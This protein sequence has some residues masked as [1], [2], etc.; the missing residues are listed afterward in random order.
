MAYRFP[1]AHHLCPRC[2]LLPPLLGCINQN[3]SASS[4]ECVV[5]HTHTWVASQGALSNGA[6][7]K[8]VSCVIGSGG[9]GDHL[10]SVS[11]PPAGGNGGHL[12]PVESSR[13][14]HSFAPPC[15]HSFACSHFPLLASSPA[16]SFPCSPFPPPALLLTHPAAHPFTHPLLFLP[17]PLRT[18]TPPRSRSQ[19][20]RR[21]V[22]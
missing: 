4:S 18:H 17:A 7:P 9:N 13:F 1:C 3:L 20:R 11:P 22:V 19:V 8:R 14:A 2:W 6:L 10:H 16:H 21:R 15:A 12:P 5:S